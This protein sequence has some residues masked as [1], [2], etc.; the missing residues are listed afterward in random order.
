MK[1]YRS[2]KPWLSTFRQLERTP[3]ARGLRLLALEALERGLLPEAKALAL[4][5]VHLAPEHH[6]LLVGLPLGEAARR[7][8]LALRDPLYPKAPPTPRLRLQEEVTAPLLALLFAGRERGLLPHPLEAYRRLLNS[9]GEAEQRLALEFATSPS[10]LPRARET[11]KEY[12]E[13]LVLFL[14]LLRRLKDYALL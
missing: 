13:A 5:A 9:L 10:L 8:S 6:A 14:R 4:G 3:D 11:P 1:S 7:S 2:L 12:L